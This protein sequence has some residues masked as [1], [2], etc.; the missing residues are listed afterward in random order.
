MSSATRSHPWIRRGALVGGLASAAA[1]GAAIWIDRHALGD[2]WDPEAPRVPEGET[3]TVVTEDGV[4]LSVVLAGPSEGPL[5]VLSH[6]W[7]GNSGIWGPVA[8]RLVAA[9]HRVVLYDQRG[10]GASTYG[11]AAPSVAMLGHDL[12]AVLDAVEATDAVVAGHSMG[13][14]SIQSYAAEHP[15]HFK[16]HVRGIVLVATA[17][18]VLGREV[19]LAAVDRI[20]GDR[21]PTWAGRGAVGRAFVRAALGRAAHRAHVDMTLDGWSSTTGYARAGFLS[22]MAGMDL[23]EALRDNGVPARVLVGSRDLLTPPRLARELARGIPGSE[24]IVLPDAG[25]M[26]P[27]ERADEVVEAIAAAAA[28]APAART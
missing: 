17:A 4:E 14:M 5:V 18:R 8:D 19:P 28:G 9:G 3:R 25:H 6:C 2:P 16:E 12:R 21:Y 11:D 22:A 15:E 27:L 7:T 26:L 1:V 20:L 10:H 24:L 23:R 13:G